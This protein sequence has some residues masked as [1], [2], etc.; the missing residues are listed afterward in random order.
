M[1]LLD[2]DALA[3]LG[4]RHGSSVGLHDE[5][6]GFG[7]RF[8]YSTGTRRAEHEITLAIPVPV[9]RA[10]H[11]FSEAGVLVPDTGHHVDDARGAFE[12]HTADLIRFT[13]IPFGINHP[14]LNPGQRFADGVGPRLGVHGVGCYQMEHF[15]AAQTFPDGQAGQFLPCRQGFGTQSVAAGGVKTN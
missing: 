2:N 1:E 15:G 11:G 9:T 14:H 3:L 6:P 13:V 8:A 4:W 12:D 5:R 10:E 7:S